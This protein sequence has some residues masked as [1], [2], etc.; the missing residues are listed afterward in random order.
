M[1]LW[2][3]Y[4]HIVWATKDRHPWITPAAEPGLYG[5]IRWKTDELGGIPHAVG[6]IEDHVHLIASIPPKLAVA[7]FIGQI[8]G[9]SSHWLNHQ[10]QLEIKFAW[11]RGYGVFSISQKNVAEAIKYVLNQK[12]HHRTGKLIP[13]LERVSMDEDGSTLESI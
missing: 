11:Q 10:G 5:H 3:L 6:G 12:E 9:S 7:D 8:K 4:Y 1:A 2:R 13:A